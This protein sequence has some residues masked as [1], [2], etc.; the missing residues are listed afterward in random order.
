[1]N[2]PDPSFVQRSVQQSSPTQDCTIIIPARL[3][4]TR[5]PGKMLLARTGRTLIEHVVYAARQAT[6]GAKV[7]VATDHDNIAKVL[8]RVNVDCVMTSP[9]HTNG[10]S[11]LAEAADLL[12][13]ADDHIVI[14]VQGDEPE[15]PPSVIDAAVH[16]LCTEPGAS[17][18]TVAC[19]LTPQEDPH[20][21]NLVKVV[22]AGTAEQKRS[23]AKALY[24][25]RSQVPFVRDAGSSGTSHRGAEPLRHVGIYAYRASF[26][27]QY[28]KFSP[29]PYELTESLEQLRALELGYSIA[30]ARDDAASGLTGI[31][32][33]EQY[34]AFVARHTNKK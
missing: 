28:A 10:T 23:V 15:I 31:D 3:G 25:S 5:L 32:T 21:P 33:I 27:R 29:T 1:V 6:I 16:A 9:A 19:A 4:S 22:L 13:L 8:A 24:F 2:Q 18:G 11:R 17:I 12:G 20:N 14:N 34:Q 7:V 30:V 26:L